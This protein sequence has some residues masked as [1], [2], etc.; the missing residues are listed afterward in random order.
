MNYWTKYSFHKKKHKY[1]ITI[2]FRVQNPLPVG[3]WKLKLLWDSHLTPGRKAVIKR[4]DNKCKRGYE[5]KGTLFAAVGCK[6]TQPWWKS[7]WTV[8]RKLKPDPPGNPVFPL[9][10]MCP[11]NS[12]SYHRDI[13]TLVLITALFIIVRKWKELNV[14]RQKNRSWKHATFIK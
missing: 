7:A 12:I 8:L 3:K 4:S 2:F 5:D 14:R 1:Q 13:C 11:E 6:L 9:L 10:D